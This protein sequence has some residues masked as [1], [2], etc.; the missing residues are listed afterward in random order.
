M[1]IRGFVHFAFFFPPSSSHFFFFLKTFSSSHTQ[2]VNISH[3]HAQTLSTRHSVFTGT[4]VHVP[5]DTHSPSA[6]DALHA[7]LVTFDLLSALTLDFSPS[8]LFK[9]PLFLS[10]GLPSSPLFLFLHPLSA[11]LLLTAGVEMWLSLHR[12]L[13]TSPRSFQQFC[14][15]VFLFH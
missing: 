2:S 5:P 15:P 12:A 10:S 4:R 14:S 9:K 6:A 11:A 1:I 8:C 7:L 13:E 3:K